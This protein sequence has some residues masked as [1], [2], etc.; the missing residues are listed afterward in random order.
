MILRIA[1]C[2][3]ETTHAETIKAYLSRFEAETG[4]TAELTVFPN[5]LPF[6]EPYRAS[7][8][9][10]LMDIRMPHM[11]GMEAA[12]QLRKLDPGVMLIFLTS[13]ENY[14]ADG[15]SV[16]AFDYILKPVRYYEFLL[17][18][19]RAIARLPQDFAGRIIVPTE[20]GVRSLL[21][22]EIYF[23]ETDGHHTICHT[24]DIAYRRYVSMEETESQ[25]SPYGFFR[26]SRFYLVNLARIDRIHGYD[27]A[28]G[29]YTIQISQPQKAA[30]LSAFKQYLKQK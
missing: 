7:W 1:L 12:K 22:N 24:A 5:P 16:D 28:L 21:P 19:K 6:L 17:K 27:L 4:N 23:V 26:C 13:L 14:A 29:P 2:E 10:V 11:D 18:M 25:L 9:I 15:Y 8:D 3:D 30:F 20:S